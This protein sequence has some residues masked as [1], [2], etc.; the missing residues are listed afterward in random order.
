MNLDVPEEQV[1]TL[2]ASLQS[3]K[4]EENNPELTDPAPPPSDLTNSA[5]FLGEDMNHPPP[6]T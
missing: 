2:V 3:S 4:F 6:K 1:E 5:H